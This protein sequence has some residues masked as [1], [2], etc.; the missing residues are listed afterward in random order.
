MIAGEGAMPNLSAFWM[1]PWNSLPQ[2][3]GFLFIMRRKAWK[4]KR[5]AAQRVFCLP[6]GRDQAL[7]PFV[8]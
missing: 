8:F 2:K 4:R 7:P 6:F 3:S 5:R 1:A